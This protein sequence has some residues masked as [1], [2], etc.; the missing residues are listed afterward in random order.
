MFQFKSGLPGEVPGEAWAR[1]HG[2]LP[3]R[4]FM[5]TDSKHWFFVVT[6]FFFFAL[7]GLSQ[8]GR[9]AR[10]CVRSGRRDPVIRAPAWQESGHTDP[11]IPRTTDRDSPSWSVPPPLLAFPL[12]GGSGFREMDTVPH[13][14]PFIYLF[15]YLFIFK[16]LFIYS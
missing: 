7:K 3:R 14:S 13:C 16:I 11:Y 8:S 4:P 1:F 10:Q 5:C 15:I 12:R 6:F 2:C 9:Q